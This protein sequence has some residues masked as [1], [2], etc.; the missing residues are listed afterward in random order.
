VGRGV[1][2]IFSWVTSLK[3][4]CQIVDQPQ[5]RHSEHSDWG[6]PGTYVF[7]HTRAR[8]G[9]ELN[10]LAYSL[11]Q[12][13]NRDAFLRDEDAYLKM[14]ALTDGQRA[15]IGR[16]DWLALIKEHGGNIYY[17]Y[18]LGATLGFGLYLMGAQMRGVSYEDFLNSRHAK[19]AR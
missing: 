1:S 2:V 7:D 13:Q 5:I 6:I 12:S 10:K 9:Y 3:Y 14:Y 17:I 16:R 19:G 15:A 11:T 4:R 18:K 8:T